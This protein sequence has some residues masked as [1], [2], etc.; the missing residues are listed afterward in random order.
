M[1]LAFADW[2]YSWIRSLIDPKVME[3]MEGRRV[4]TI[5]ISYA[6]PG[7]AMNHATKLFLESGC[8]R[9]IVVDLDQEWQPRD[10]AFLL[11]H[12]VPLV[13]GMYCKKQMA[14]EFVLQALEPG[15]NPFS[16]KP[17][18]IASNPLVEVAMVSRGFIGI[19]RSVF[20]SVHNTTP[21]I[22]DTQTG[23]VIRDYWAPM[24]NGHSEDFAFCKRYREAGGKVF[25]DQ[26]IRIHHWG[27]QKFPVG[28]MELR[29]ALS[30]YPVKEN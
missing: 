9:L 12:D 14:M 30:Y 7:G 21:A 26:R 11:S 17:E 4:V 23:E 29:D 16:D 20:D 15:G 6:Y 13:A 19:H 25:C 5:R 28:E 18:E 24:P 3:Q 10:L 27:P 1:K 2:G 8:D 22:H